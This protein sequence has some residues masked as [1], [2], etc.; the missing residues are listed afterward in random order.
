VISRERLNWLLISALGDKELVYKWWQSPNQAF[1][2]ATPEQIW[3][4]E[5]ERVANYIMRAVNVGG[6]YF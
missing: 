2:Y 1:E 6:D 4:E 3:S 5:P